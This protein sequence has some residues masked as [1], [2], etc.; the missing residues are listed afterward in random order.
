MILAQYESFE[1]FYYSIPLPVRIVIYVLLGILLFSL[2][3]MGSHGLKNSVKLTNIGSY[4][5]LTL[6]MSKK[7]VM[8]IMNMK[9]DVVYKDKFIYEWRNVHLNCDY[10]FI[11]ITLLFEKGRLVDIKHEKDKVVIDRSKYTFK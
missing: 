10:D 2:V 8:E 5:K 7:E 3:L 11:K 1:E 6:G 9:P 4:E